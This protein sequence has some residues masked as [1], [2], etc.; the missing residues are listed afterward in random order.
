ML[1]PLRIQYW[2]GAME[3][4]Y[5]FYRPCCDVSPYLK[6]PTAGINFLRD[7]IHCPVIVMEEPL[8][9]QWETKMPILVQIN[10]LI[11]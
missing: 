11:Y 7:T 2:V 10:Q 3:K 9:P 8:I 4:R 1:F 5:T 6:D